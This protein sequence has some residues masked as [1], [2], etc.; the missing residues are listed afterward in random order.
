MRMKVENV[1]KEVEV[2]R[3][4]QRDTGS[5]TERFS[6]GFPQMKINIHAGTGSAAGRKFQTHHD[7]IGAA[8]NIAIEA[9]TEKFFGFWKREKKGKNNAG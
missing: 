9:H 8:E 4:R 2:V 5:Q 1:E 7:T 6:H 3:H